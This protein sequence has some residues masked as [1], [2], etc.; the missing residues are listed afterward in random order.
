M[1]GIDFGVVKYIF[2]ILIV[3]FSPLMVVAQSA[4][5]GQPLVREGDFALKLA[6][7]LGVVST[8]DEV[9]AESSLGELDILPRNGWIADYPVT[10]DVIIEL[11]TVVGAASSDGRLSITE[12]EAFKKFNDVIVSF[13]LSISPNV[14]GTN[15]TPPQANCP[16]YADTEELINSY[17]AEGPPVVTY[18]CPLTDYYY[19]YTWVPC[20]FWWYDLSFRGFFILNDFHRIIHRHGKI[21]IATNHFNDFK[22]HHV[23]RIDP[24]ERFKGKTFAGIGVSRPKDFIST[25]IPKSERTIFNGSHA[26]SATGSVVGNSSSREGNAVMASPH[27]ERSTFERSK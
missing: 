10:P 13:G 4:P 1:R 14:S 11:H 9:E 7:E 21:A 15:N 6:S 17:S 25:G 12:E 2:Y 18:Y 24:V 20:P 3:M 16:N 8:D 5:I 22:S 27:G 23:F 19:L 26:R